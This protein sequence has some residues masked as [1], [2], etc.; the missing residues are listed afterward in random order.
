V[1][2]LCFGG[3]NEKSIFALCTLC[4]VYCSAVPLLR[5]ITCTAVHHHDYSIPVYTYTQSFIIIIS[6]LDFL[7]KFNNYFL[8]KQ[9][10]TNDE[11]RIISAKESNVRRYVGS[12]GLVITSMIYGLFPS[13]RTFYGPFSLALAIFVAIYRTGYQSL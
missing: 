10:F 11:N 3:E 5:S 8:M 6:Y 4:C 13:S 7:I 12:I 9:I 2:S 1:R